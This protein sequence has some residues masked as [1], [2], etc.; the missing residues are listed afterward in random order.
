MKVRADIAELLYAGL[1]D[2]AIARQLGVDRAAAVA[3]A[4]AALRLPKAKPGPKAYASAE[5]LFWRRV[6]PTDDGH[7]EWTGFHVGR[8]PAMRHGGRNL[9]ACSIAYRIANGR[10][11]KGQAR[12][13]CGRDHCVMPGHHA[14]Q[15]DRAHARARSKVIQAW[16]GGLRRAGR[17]LEREREKRVDALYAQIFGTPE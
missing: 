12:P 2:S 10:P 6:K 16:A 1:S 3:P 15:A 9:T 8:T 11:A 14:D 5:D 7:M 13:S 4:R 17:A